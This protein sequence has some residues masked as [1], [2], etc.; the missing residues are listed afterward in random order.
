MIVIFLVA[1]PWPLAI[2]CA[3]GSAL[4][5]ISYRKCI[6]DVNQQNGLI[7]GVPFNSSKFKYP[8]P[9]DNVSLASQ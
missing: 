5:Y 6:Y 9:Q 4:Q 1:S 8:A 3:L 7:P 2:G